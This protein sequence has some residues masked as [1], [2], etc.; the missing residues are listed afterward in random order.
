M[1]FRFL[2]RAV[3]VVMELFSMH[4][5]LFSVLVS[6]LCYY[7]K[8]RIKFSLILNKFYVEISSGFQ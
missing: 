8:E 7:D 1:K 4:F 5:E 2:I 3:N 6:G